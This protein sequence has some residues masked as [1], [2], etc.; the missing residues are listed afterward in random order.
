MQINHLNKI[1]AEEITRGKSLSECEQCGDDSDL[2]VIVTRVCG[3]CARK[4]HKKA[5][6]K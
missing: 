2:L 3:K 5:L 4:N 1:R 6:G